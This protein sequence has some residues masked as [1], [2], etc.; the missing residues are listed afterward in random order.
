M[1]ERYAVVASRIRQELAELPHVVARAQRAMAAAHHADEDADLFVDAAALNLHDFYA[2]LERLLGQIATLIDRS[3][4]SGHDWHRE[5]L[6]QM[7]TEIA[8][9][10]P[11]V[12]SAETAK[13]LDE[14]LR[15]RHVVRNIYAFEFDSEQIER[16]VRELQPAHTRTQTE[17]LVFAEFLDRL[18][19]EQ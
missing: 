18:A 2:G 9:L 5:L 15:F 8:G 6:R 16:L 13:L 7:T 14:Y 11:A 12:V 1:I 10:R 17:L 3:M 4:P 19:N